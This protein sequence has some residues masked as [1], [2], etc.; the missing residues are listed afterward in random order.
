VGLDRR[1]LGEHP[2][3]RHTTPAANFVHPLTDSTEAARERGNNVVNVV[4]KAPV[5][6]FGAFLVSATG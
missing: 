3:V 1:G 6:T 4:I 5:T 2:N